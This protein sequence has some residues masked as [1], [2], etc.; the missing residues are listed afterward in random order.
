MGVGPLHSTGGDRFEQ[1]TAGRITHGTGATDDIDRTDSTCT[2]SRTPHRLNPEPCLFT[3][4]TKPAPIIAPLTRPQIVCGKLLSYEGV[5]VTTTRWRP[6]SI[7]VVLPETVMARSHHGYLLALKHY[8]LPPKPP[9]TR[10][11]KFSP[12]SLFVGPMDPTDVWYCQNLHPAICR[13]IPGWRCA[14]VALKPC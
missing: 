13:A 6:L 1:P 5:V 12:T 10:A 14:G 4:P 2:A 3:L 7:S 9:A 8:P 11:L